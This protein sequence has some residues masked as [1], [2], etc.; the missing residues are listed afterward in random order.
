MTVLRL[1]LNSTIRL[2]DDQF[3]HLWVE[4]PQLKRERIVTGKLVIIPPTRG[5]TGQH[6]SDLNLELVPGC[7][8]LKA[9]WVLL[10]PPRLGALSAE[11]RYVCIE[12]L[13]WL[14][15]K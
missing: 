10:K 3:Y 9:N 5:E 6:N 13:R 2:N 7:S 11:N 15:L 4:K 12:L 14:A 8:N 1:N